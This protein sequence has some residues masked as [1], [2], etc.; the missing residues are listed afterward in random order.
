MN[1]SILIRDIS[2]E[3]ME[4]LE[5]LKKMYGEK[6]GAKVVKRLILSH[7]KQKELIDNQIQTIQ[8]LKGDIET[9]KL[10]I[11]SFKEAVDFFNEQC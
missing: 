8:D 5:A 7:L 9:F 2:P 3:E 6:T 11:S 4:A 10:H 1:N